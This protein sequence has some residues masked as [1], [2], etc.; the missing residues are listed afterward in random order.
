MG[1]KNISVFCLQ[2]VTLYFKGMQRIFL[3]VILAHLLFHDKTK[4][5]YYHQKVD[6]P[7][8]ERLETQDL[9]K[10]GNF[11]KAPEM[12]AGYPKGKF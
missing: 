3:H 7:V 2:R 5:G 1:T 8:A 4:L 6:I 11:K 10:L 12:P 9:K